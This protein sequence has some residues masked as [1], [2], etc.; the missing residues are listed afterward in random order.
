MKPKDPRV[1]ATQVLA[2]T[3]RKIWGICAGGN[4]DRYESSVFPG[5]DGLTPGGVVESDGFLSRTGRF[6]G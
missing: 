2:K 4:V 3:W 6:F 1:E 5:Y